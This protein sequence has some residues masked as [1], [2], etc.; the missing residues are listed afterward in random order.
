M[1]SQFDFKTKHLK[2]FD[3]LLFQ[4]R[5][6][7]FLDA[8]GLSPAQEWC[9]NRSATRG[10]RILTDLGGTHFLVR[11][12][13][14]VSF[15]KFCF[16]YKIQAQ[17]LP[18]GQAA[19]ADLIRRLQA[20]FDKIYSVLLKIRITISFRV[21]SSRQ[22]QKFDF[23]IFE[24]KSCEF[25]NKNKMHQDSAILGDFIIELA[26]KWKLKIHRQISHIETV[27]YI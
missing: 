10:P 1:Y 12:V 3:S 9:W 6:T 23:E 14:S 5:C 25:F 13:C 27:M 22:R 17:Y 21:V 26:S 8:T 18:C 4:P 24:I 20:C 15:F 11:F 16:V 2:G 19:S 7:Q